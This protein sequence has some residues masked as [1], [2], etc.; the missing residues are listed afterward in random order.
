MPSDAVA[1]PRRAFMTEAPA[2]YLLVYLVL[3]AWLLAGFA[4][5]VCHRIQRIE[6][7]NG[8]RESLLHWLMLGE[9]G[10][11]LLAAVFLKID[12]FLIAL[13]IVCWMAH[14]VTTHFD[15]KLAVRTREVPAYEQ[16]V[17][18]FLEVLPVAALLLICTLHWQQAAALFGLGAARADFTIALSA[19]PTAWQLVLLSGALLL[20][21]AIPYSEELAR[22]IFA[23]RAKRSGDPR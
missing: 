13:M 21:G 23:Q 7:A 12:A 5:Y 6:Q 22:G 15:L 10:I 18:S 8:V 19:G 16:Q 9:V 2:W 4:D 17:H 3:P 20:F 11:P 14:E 1:G